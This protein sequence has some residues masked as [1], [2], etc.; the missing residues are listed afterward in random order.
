MGRE[1][2]CLLSLNL[3]N[4][5]RQ[6]IQAVNADRTVAYVQSDGYAPNSSGKPIPQY[7]FPVL[8]QAQIQPP[9]GRDLKHM[10]YLNIQGT[11]RTVFLYSNP[12]AIVRVDARGGDLLV[13]P[14]FTGV[15]L[16]NWLVTWVDETWDVG[17]GGWTKLYATLQTDR[18]TNYLLDTDGN[19]L[20]DDDGNVLLAA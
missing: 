11:T 20:T 3:H 18:P 14:Q 15:P 7:E 6:A 19:F 10:E 16:D 5:V 17:G 1:E 8:V 12:Q 9:S 4:I 13:F 2:G